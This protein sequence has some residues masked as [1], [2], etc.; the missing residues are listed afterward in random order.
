MEKQNYQRKPHPIMRKFWEQCTS[1]GRALQAVLDPADTLG[2]KNKFIDILQKTALSGY[3]TLSGRETI[4]DFGC[5][6][7][8][9]TDWLAD[10]ASFIVGIDVT[11]EMLVLAKKIVHKENSMFVHYDGSNFPLKDE[12]F[13]VVISVWVLQYILEE[14]VHFHRVV[15]EIARVLKKGGIIYLIEQVSDRN[16]NKDPWIVQ[17]KQE[18]YT[19]IFS[20]HNCNCIVKFHMSNSQSLFRYILSQSNVLSRFIPTF[21]FQALAKLELLYTRKRKIPPQGHS[22]YLFVFRKGIE[23]E[24]S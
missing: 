23:S 5:G 9:L 14:K 4:L 6:C 22:D 15:K 7:G 21:M 12:S 20:K 17:R 2:K 24:N 1:E 3:L 18:E 8:R 16:H 10:K 19:Q 13:D 11:K